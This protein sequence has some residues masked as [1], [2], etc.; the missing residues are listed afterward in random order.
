MS[1]N[2]V[3]F[4]NLVGVFKRAFPIAVSAVRGK[5][6]ATQT[7]T[8]YGQRYAIVGIGET[9]VYAYRVFSA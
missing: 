6:G 2:Q 4:S 7:V 5:A 9:G 8:Y 3:E 1:I